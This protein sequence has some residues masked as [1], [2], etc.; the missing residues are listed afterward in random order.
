MI[1]WNIILVQQTKILYVIWKL[2]KLFNLWT[3]WIY[4]S[5]YGSIIIQYIVLI[6]STVKILY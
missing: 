3:I 6:H 4:G 2:A 5:I 1:E